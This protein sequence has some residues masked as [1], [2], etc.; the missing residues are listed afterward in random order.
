MI[1]GTDVRTTKING[2]TY[3]NINDLIR[4]INEHGTAVSTAFTKEE[5]KR[6]YEMGYV[7]ITELLELIKD[8]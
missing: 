8:Y 3:A 2:E 5:F 6:A 7:H 4:K 1:K